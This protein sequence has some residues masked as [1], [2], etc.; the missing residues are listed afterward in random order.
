MCMF[1]FGLFMFSARSA[2]LFSA[3]FSAVLLR[4]LFGELRA[5]LSRRGPYNTPLLLHVCVFK[6]SIIHPCVILPLLSKYPGTAPGLTEGH[7]GGGFGIS[8]YLMF[9]SI[10][11]VRN[12]VPK[13]N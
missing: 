8:L 5:L 12:F 13:L 6:M 3:D 9:F 2:R 7:M 11:Q 4:K 1:C 10:H